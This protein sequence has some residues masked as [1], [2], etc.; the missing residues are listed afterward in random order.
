VIENY[1]E[2]QVEEMEAVNN[3]EDPS[4]GTRRVPFSRVLYIEQDDF[5]EDPPKKYYRLAP[6]REVRLR[7]AYYVTCREA[8]KD[9]QT[10]ELVE[11]RCTYDPATR[12][13]SSPDGRKV[14]GTIHWVSAEHALKAEV[15]LYDHLFMKEDADDV[16]AGKDYRS[17]L[18]PE[19]LVVLNEVPVEPS[20]RD[21]APDQ[22]L[23]FERLGYFCVD[24]TDSK[25][26]KLVFNRTVTLRDTW[27]KIE[28][29]GKSG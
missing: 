7:Y 27:A 22:P 11:L 23:Q 2:G 10:G 20:L 12:G 21:A 1:P 24:R 5:R 29:K 13:G 28:Q 19:S 8:V 17:N 18:N 9:P 4:M 3:P 6:G 14:Q 16:P 25:A 15:R 26:D